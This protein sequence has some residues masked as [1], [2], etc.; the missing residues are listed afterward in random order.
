MKWQRKSDIK[1]TMLPDGHIALSSDKVDWVHVL[2]PVGALVWELSDGNTTSDEIFCQIQELIPS[3]DKI[4]LK[5][6]IDQ[7]TKELV[8]AGV[9]TVQ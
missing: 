7:F 2:N 1:T 3:G 4:V 8:D 6:D 5:E 9:L